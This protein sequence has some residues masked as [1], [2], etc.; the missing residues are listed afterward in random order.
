[1]HVI[2]EYLSLGLYSFMSL[3]ILCT[4]VSSLSL[5]L[6]LSLLYPD[7]T[8]ISRLFADVACHHYVTVDSEQVQRIPAEFALWAF[9]QCVERFQDGRF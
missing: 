8:V 7:I 6:S 9:G 5:S 4:I 3:D 2:H 1:M